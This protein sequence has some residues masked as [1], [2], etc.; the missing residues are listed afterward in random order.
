MKIYPVIILAIVLMSGAFAF[1]ENTYPYEL[2]KGKTNEMI[3]V[4]FNHE[5]FKLEDASVSLSM[6]DLDYRAKPELITVRSNKYGKAYF[7]ID[8]PKNIEPDYYPV[9][10]TLNGDY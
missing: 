5:K 8:V 4:V 3:V 2:E 9:I 1:I 7:E 10:I 6:P